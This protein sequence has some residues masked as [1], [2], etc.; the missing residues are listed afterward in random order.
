MT[1]LRTFLS[2]SLFLFRFVHVQPFYGRPVITGIFS[3]YFPWQ[4]GLRLRRLHILYKFRCFTIA[5]RTK[6]EMHKYSVNFIATKKTSSKWH[7][8]ST[9]LVDV[10]NFS[11]Q[12]IFLRWWFQIEIIIKKKSVTFAIYRY[13]NRNKQKPL[14][15]VN[16]SNETTN[17]PRAEKTTLLQ[18]LP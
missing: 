14:F 13:R 8:L 17:V 12:T 10:E 1:K 7:N 16:K 3:I 4:K 2:L 9:Y 5:D 11:L 18:S 15:Y 6:T